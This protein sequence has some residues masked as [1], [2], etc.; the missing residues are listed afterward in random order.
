MADSYHSHKR[1][2]ILN[3]INHLG[4]ISRTQLTALTEYRPATVGEITKEL[5]DAGIIAETGRCST[6]H[7]RKRTMLEVDRA[8]LYAIG[9][10]FSNES[11]T[12]IVA[13]I[14]GS[15]VEEGDIW[16]ELGTPKEQ[17][18]SKIVS[19]VQR[20]LEKYADKEFVG[21]GI[22]DPLYD[23]VR[24]QVQD[25]L[26]DAYGHFNDWVHLGLKPEL[27]SKT[28]IPVASFSPVILPALAEKR[29]GVAQNAR[30]FICVEL[31]NGVGT[32]ICCGGVV[33][34][35]AHGVA[36]ELGHM[37]IDYSDPQKKLCYCGKSGCV[38]NRTAYPALARD[39]CASLD[40]GVFSLLN[41]YYD[42][43][44]ELSVQDIR[45]ALD[46]GD[47][48]C[49]H[50]V[51]EV[52]VRLG[53]AIANAVNLLNPELVV[54]YGFMLEL[55]DFFLGQLENSIRENILSMAKN[56]DIRISSSWQTTLPLGA[57][58]EIF[59]EY[60]KADDFRW[61]YQMQREDAAD[62]GIQEMESI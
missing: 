31:S 61:I 51:K 6:G 32:S 50:Y 42:R 53:V 3:L 30:D 36:G 23:P 37:V 12:Y 2:L 1:H 49:M 57:V 41:A 56:F 25:S 17:L 10:A 16:A 34:G 59:S 47:Q 9:L 40:R 8:F 43:T 62:A 13:Q 19:C 28:K 20:L 5:L 45:R 35:G 38:E 39:I 22:C 58:A 33:V 44:Q 11:V 46:G 4:P 60:L 55:G 48:M 18:A 21:I 52:A 29:F 24:Y 15:I 27:E 54:L 7:G 26:L 14:D